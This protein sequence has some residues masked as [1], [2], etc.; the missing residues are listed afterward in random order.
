M[1]LSHSPSISTNGLMLYLDAA[2]PKS[3]P[4]SGTTWTDMISSKLFSASGTPTFNSTG[5][6]TFNGTSDYFSNSSLNSFALNTSTTVYV[7]YPTYTVS[8]GQ[9]VNISYRS[10][11]GGRLYV[12]TQS[13]VIF[14]YYDSLS[15][16]NYTNGAITVNSWNICAV[17]T[18]S[19]A[20]TI[21]H[22]VNGSLSGTSASRTGFSAVTNTALH[23]G[24]DGPTNEYFQGRISQV[25]V[26]NRVLT[27]AEI[28]QIFN[29]MRGRYGI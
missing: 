1:G 20:G 24:Y 23:I 5:Y 19:G 17:T 3:Y 12:G 18:D 22:Y 28:L 16:P 11:F 29:A 9:R 15:T 27:A 25:M 6:F 10:G 2:N 13:G 14:S 21:S 7:T 26:Y 8:G 4:G